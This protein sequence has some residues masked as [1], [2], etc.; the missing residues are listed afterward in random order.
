MNSGSAPLAGHVPNHPYAPV[1][2][3][4]Q[5]IDARKGNLIDRLAAALQRA[6]LWKRRERKRL[7]DARASGDEAAVHA[8]RVRYQR[9]SHWRAVFY[10]TYVRAVMDVY[11]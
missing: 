4:W 8:A 5:G 7:V 10:R 1:P 11:A 2:I 6:R 9:A 3:H